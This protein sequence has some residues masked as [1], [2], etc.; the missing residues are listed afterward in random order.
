VGFCSLQHTQARRSTQHGLCLSPLRSACRVWLPS[1]RLTPF[2]PQPVMFRTGGAPGIHPSELSPLAR[3][4]PRFRAEAP[5]YRFSRRLSR[6]KRWAGPTGRGFWVFTLARV[7]GRPN[8]VSAQTAGCSLGLFPSRACQQAALLGPSS[9]LLP[10]ACHT[11][12]SHAWRH[13]VSIG[14]RLALP[15]DPGKPGTGNTT[16]LGFQHRRYPEH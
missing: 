5:T 3:F 13:G 2:G 15:A 8:A 6:R 7:P 11:A 14:I 9:G 16:L 12:R 1:G 4:P 10:R